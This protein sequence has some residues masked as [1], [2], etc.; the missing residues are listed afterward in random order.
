M[1]GSVNPWGMK[2]GKVVIDEEDNRPKVTQNVAGVDINEYVEG[3][4]KAKLARAKPL[5]D[6]IEKSSKTLESLDT[7]KTKF[8]L[9]QSLAATMGNRISRSNPIQSIF[10]SKTVTTTKATSDAQFTASASANIAPFNLTVNQ[11]ASND[12]RNFL[13]QATDFDTTPLG[14]TG[15]LSLATSRPGTL[16]ALTI[17]NTM[18][19]SD[20]QDLI[21]S[22]SSTTTIKAGITQ[23]AVGSPKNTY[24]LN[25]STE[26]TGQA[27]VI[28]NNTTGGVLTT[29]PLPSSYIAGLLPRDNEVTSLN[30]TGT[31]TLTSSGGSPVQL[32]LTPT[33]SL[34]DVVNTINGQTS[35]TGVQASFTRVYND[36]SGKNSPVFQLKLTAVNPSTL[37]P[38][39][40]KTITLGDPSDVGNMPNE[41]GLNAPVTDYD[42][43]VAKVNYNGV[44][45]VRQTNAIDG[46]SLETAII[47]GVNITLKGASQTLIQGSVAPDTM[48]FFTRFNDF[49]TAYNDLTVYYNQQIEIDEDTARPKENAHLANNFMIQKA[50]L[51]LRSALA[52][53]VYGNNTITGLMQLGFTTNTDGTILQPQDMTSFLSALQNNFSEL[54]HLFTNVTTFSN[55]KFQIQELPTGSSLK[56]AGQTIN[57]QLT[58][59][60]NLLSGSITIGGANYNIKTLSGNQT[61]GGITFQIDDPS[62]TS[63]LSGLTLYHGDPIA[64]NTTES[65]TL[66]ITQGIMAKIDSQ[67]LSLFDETPVDPNAK[68]SPLKGPYFQEINKIKESDKKNKKEIDSI[69]K[70]ANE[71]SKR[72]EREFEK[73]YQATIQLESIMTMIEGFNQVN[74]R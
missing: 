55:S 13:I 54:E 35:T 9:V 49:I 8:E 47:P 56:Y 40:T 15:T 62:N 30:L 26:Q 34:T 37:Q 72:L 18:T 4:K 36:N 5:E 27:I 42:T 74:R 68:D 25:L 38:D 45:Y 7:F 33:M 12:M 14:I 24:V 59:T 21:N 32:S 60:N 43:L 67:G 65:S 44:N 71:T 11:L 22:E 70:E 61:T 58:N 20:I 29:P 16:K 39:T 31:M 63:G 52:N 53:P 73:V 69:K 6:K 3:M 51:D 46:T 48:E 66:T 64:N 10:D 2:L 57:L 19:L 28:N 50:I 1:V 41:L 17:T 23:V